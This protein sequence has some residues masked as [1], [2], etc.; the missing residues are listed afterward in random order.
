MAINIL[1]NRFRK[2]TDAS[3]PAYIDDEEDDK[4]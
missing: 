2:Q 1:I 4:W 3:P